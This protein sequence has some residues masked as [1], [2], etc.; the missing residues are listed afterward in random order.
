MTST[1][2]LYEILKKKDNSHQS[3]ARVIG[4]K[5]K[6]VFPKDEQESSYGKSEI[7]HI[8]CIVQKFIPTD[9]SIVT[10]SSC[11]LLCFLPNLNHTSRINDIY[12]YIYCLLN[13]SIDNCISMRFIM[14]NRDTCSKRLNITVM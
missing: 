10:S 13:K 4:I 7:S 2:H 1:V 8:T 6:R 3:N 5:N 14:V 12:I 11:I 9:K